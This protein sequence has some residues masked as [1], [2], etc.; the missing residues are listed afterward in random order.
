MRGEEEKAGFLSPASGFSNSA[1]GDLS[2]R[3]E[4]SLSGRRRAAAAQV[5]LLQGWQTFLEIL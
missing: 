3:R 4:R 2:R 1:T 5:A